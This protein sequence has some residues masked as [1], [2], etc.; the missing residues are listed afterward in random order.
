MKEACMAAKALLVGINTYTKVPLR[1]C[2]NDVMRVRNLLTQRYHLADDRLRII[3]DGEATKAA[4]ADG[5]GWLAQP[6]PDGTAPVRLFHFSGH[7]VFIPDEDH[8]EEDGRDECL[9]PVDYETAGY[10]TDDTLRESYARF[11]ANTHL[12]L[13]MDCCHSG[14]IQRDIANDIVYRYLKGAEEEE[15]RLYDQI[16]A[17]QQRN[18]EL[19][20]AFVAAE[21][22][23]LLQREPAT[24]SEDELQRQI[25][26]VM[27]KFD[28][29][30]Y[31]LEEMEGN[32][33]LIAACKSDQ[34]A[35]DAHFGETY[36]GALTYYLSEA[37]AGAGGQMP[38]SAL[39]ASIGQAM[40]DRFTQV[41]QLECSKECIDLPFLRDVLS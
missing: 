20:E 8:D 30:H 17:A 22:T 14:G 3:I 38:Y 29:V 13:L 34:T 31:G 15:T 35:A 24:M 25:K 32:A 5:L 40:R 18:R 41:P 23:K 1:G 7:G 26:A 6:D 10:I 36:N 2:V 37:L 21:M 12:L 4:I 9:V 39:I 27:D 16:Q 33:L 11:S 28:K 19:K